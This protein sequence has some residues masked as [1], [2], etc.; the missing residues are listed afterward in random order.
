MTAPLVPSASRRD[1]LRSGAGAATLAALAP[2]AFAAEPDTTA[3]VI[4]ELIRFNDQ[5]IPA[6]L[7]SQERR[8][9]H[10]WVGGQINDYG[11]HSA[12]GTKALVVAYTCALCSE[13]GKYRGSAEVAE[14]LGR[15][16]FWPAP[17]SRAE[18]GEFI[19]REYQTWGKVIRERNISGR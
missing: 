17:T 13:G 11:L 19:A 15:H 1:F 12:T 7:A 4:R 16:G 5:R 6:L 10:R 8:P 9:G 2:R 18:L 3:D 14:A